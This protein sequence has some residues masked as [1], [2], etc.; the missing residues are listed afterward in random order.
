MVRLLKSTKFRAFKKQIYGFDIE[1]YDNNKEFLMASIYKDDDNFWFFHDKRKLINFFKTKRF[2]NSVV[3]ATN[4]GFDFHGTF[5]NEKESSKF[6]LLYRGSDILSATTHIRNKDF[7][8]D[9]RKRGGC[10]LQFIDTMNFARMSVDK[11]GSI[12]ALPKLEKPLFLGTIPDTPNKWKEMREYN[13]RDSKIS[14]LSLSFLFKSFH[15]LGATPKPTIASTAMSLFK[16]KYLGDKL[17]YRHETEHLLT[18][19]KAYYGGRTEA[20]SRGHFEDYNYYDFNSLY[21]SVMLNEFP[22]PNS[23][24]KNRKNTVDYIEAYEGISHVDV[25][26]PYMEYPLLPLRTKTKLLFPYGQF[27]GWYSHV[28]LRKAMQLGYIIKKVKR[29]F[30]FKETCFPFKDYVNDL[31]NLRL[32]YKKENNPMELVVKLLLNSLYGKFA[33]KFKG[34][35]NWIHSDNVT[36]DILEKQTSIE[37]IGEYFRF[38][39]DVAASAF[40]FPIWSLY[41]T[42]YGRLKLHEYMLKS[43]PIYVDTDSI[44]TKKSFISSDKIGKLKLEMKIKEGT[45]VKP[46]FYAIHPHGSAAFVKAKGLGTRL[47]MY[48][49]RKLMLDPVFTYKKFMKFKESVRRGF[50]PNEIQDMTKNLNLEDDK[51]LWESKFDFRKFQISRPLNTLEIEI[52]QFVEHKTPCYPHPS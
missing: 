28:E 7:S 12:L 5:Y 33:Q 25:E 50:I 26:C 40:C 36:L 6:K 9:A 31:Y 39:Y 42:A 15:D 11:L 49:F 48:D 35:D 47:S 29:T 18:E 23:L 10:S 14:K 38:K 19:F 8:H 51:R 43:N 30:Y 17:Y 32:E 52:D 1:T 45:I 24:R 20:F 27:S 41:V 22:D 46:K 34:R 16:N 37:R 2:K 21:P 4:L 44:I 3:A 13:L